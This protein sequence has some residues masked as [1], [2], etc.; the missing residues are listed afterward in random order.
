MRWGLLL[1]LLAPGLCA[2]PDEATGMDA[3]LRQFNA[4]V[5]WYAS[6]DDERAEAELA[7]GTAAPLRVEGAL[8]FAP[9]RHGRAL[10]GGTLLYSGARH[11]DLAASGTL[12]V[13]VR[14]ARATPPGRTEGYHFLVRLMAGD[15]ALPHGMLMLG[16]Q[17]G[18]PGANLYLH[19]EASGQPAA[20]L[21]GPAT[22]EWLADEWHLLA[23]A[24]RPGQ[25]LLSLDGAPW[26]THQAPRLPAGNPRLLLAAAD[27]P[28][29]CHLD[30][31]LLLDSPLTDAE[32]AWIYRTLAP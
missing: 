7:V 11:L 17:G 32:L 24:W 22:H 10:A 28:F 31:L 25:M 16:K 26:L 20:P 14:I 8:A 15:A 5:R 30:D 13:W 9:G 18:I 23:L 4:Q 2:G 3:V 1:W 21:R 19:A 29:A 6:F 27:G 12:L